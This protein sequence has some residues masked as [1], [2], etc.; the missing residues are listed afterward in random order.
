MCSYCNYGIALMKVCCVFRECLTY[1]L[2]DDLILLFVA[3]IEL[4]GLRMPY[5]VIYENFDLCA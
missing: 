2:V 5:F 4:L 1:F 3:L